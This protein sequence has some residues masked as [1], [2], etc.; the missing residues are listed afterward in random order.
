MKKWKR[1]KDITLTIYGY[2][3]REMY[4]AAWLAIGDRL[5]TES[6]QLKADNSTT[7]HIQ[8]RNREI[9]LHFYDLLKQGVPVMLAYTMTGDRFYLSE[10]R[11]RQIVAKRK[12]L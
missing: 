7:M 8:R 6:W 10:E 9:R 12:A 5:T 11:V 3:F 4:R 2:V 1:C